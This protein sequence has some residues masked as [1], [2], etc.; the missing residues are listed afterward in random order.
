M[1]GVRG[2]RNHNSDTSTR[3]GLFGV[4]ELFIGRQDNKWQSYVGQNAA[5]PAEDADA[6][7]EEIEE[8]EEAPA[9]I[10]EYFDHIAELKKNNAVFV[11]VDG[12]ISDAVSPTK[13][14]AAAVEADGA[15]AIV[16][17]GPVS[18]RILD[19]AS[20]AAIETV[21][22]TKEGKGFSSRDDVKAWLTEKHA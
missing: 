1:G 22:G 3:Q 4:D 6:W 10:H 12:T 19:I 5:N 18:D 7:L 2:K 13:L 9:E 17:N 14:A 20:E 8:P 16:F 21:V 15:V 11:N